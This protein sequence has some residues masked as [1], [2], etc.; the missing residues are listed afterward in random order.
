MNSR[1]SV[2]QISQALFETDPMNTCCKENDC[3]DEY[4]GVAGDIVTRIGEGESLK[5]ALMTE[6]SEWFFDGE[7]FDQSRLQPVL[8]R[9]G[10]EEK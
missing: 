1:H 8:E 3:F 6:M 5:R 10:K 2:Q 4:D 7:H 9:L